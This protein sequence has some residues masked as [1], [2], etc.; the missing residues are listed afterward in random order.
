[1]NGWQSTTLRGEPLRVGD[2][3]VIPEA[4]VWSL[5]FK[6]AVVNETQ[7][8][9]GGFHW[10]WARPT[11]LIDRTAGVERRLPVIDWNRRLEVWLLVAAI[12]LPVILLAVPRLAQQ[13][14][15]HR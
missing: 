8:A 10:S 15:K 6:R 5:E 3:E 4:R 11:V 13:L 9:G 2:H 7:L 1:M 14:W 12:W